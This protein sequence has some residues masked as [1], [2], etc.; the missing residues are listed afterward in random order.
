VMIM[1][2]GLDPAEFVVKHG[3]DEVRQAA[4]TARPLVEYMVRRVIGRHDLTSIEGQS[5]AVAE[6]LP[7]L[8]RLQDPV[9][10]SEYAGLVA[11]LAGVSEVSVLQSLQQ[12]LSGKPQEVAGTIR[13]G[14]AAERAEREWLRLMARG[15]DTQEGEG[16]TLTEDHFR[17][18]TN[19]RLYVALRDAGGDVAA[20]AGGEDQKLAGPVAA[21]AV[22][23][24]EG[25]P[26][27][28]YATAVARRLD[29]FLLKGRSDALRTRL[30]KL[31][32]TVDPGYDEL[33]RE[34]VEVDGQLRRLRQ[35]PGST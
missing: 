19:R 11:D 4:A 21:L 29:E 28:A 25:D 27:P 18:A 10:R 33:F 17:N 12:R 7:L 14:T 8:D 35:E 32:P 13:R 1:P 6:A 16:T 22:E 31:N 2:D 34:L 9:R 24:L 26:T 3:A 5:A 23:P 15:A 20:L 30:Q